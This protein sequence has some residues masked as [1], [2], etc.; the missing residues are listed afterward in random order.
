MK[1]N[2]SKPEIAFESFA[3]SVSIAGCGI[4]SNLP[5]EVDQCGFEWCGDTIFLTGYQGCPEDDSYGTDDGNSGF[6][7]HN[8]TESTQL[9]GS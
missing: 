6:C 1:K 4:E 3:V 9:F 5:T 7:Y 8:P 2:Y